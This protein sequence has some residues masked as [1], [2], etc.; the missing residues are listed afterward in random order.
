MAAYCASKAG[1]QMFTKVA[2][3]ELGPLGINVNAISPGVV[4]TPLTEM[5]LNMP[6]LK[7]GFLERTPKMRIGEPEDIARVAL[8]LAS[9]YADWVTGQTIAVDGGLSLM[10]LPKYYEGVQQSLGM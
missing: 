10:G 3:L 1:I 7:E 2:A 5:L 8:F 4:A 9:E 6:L